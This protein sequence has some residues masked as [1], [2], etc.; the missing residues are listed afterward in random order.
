MN[1]NQIISQ[2]L[3]MLKGVQS[4]P[5]F[6]TG[7]IVQGQILKLYPGRK[8]EI[9]IGLHKLIAQLEASLTLGER[10]NFQVQT[11]KDVIYLKVLG[12][13]LIKQANENGMALLKQLGLKENK[14]HAAFLQSLMAEGIPFDIAQLRQA[15]KLLD[16]KSDKENA[17]SILKQMLATKF[18]LTDSVFQALYSQDRSLFSNEIKALKNL[19]NQSSYPNLLE[20]KVLQKLELLLHRPMSIRDIFLKDAVRE[21]NTNRQ[22]VF[23]LLKLTGYIDYHTDFNKWEKSIKSHM[24]NKNLLSSANDKNNILTA[25]NHQQITEKLEHIKSAQ[26]KIIKQSQLV[27]TLFLNKIEQSILSNQPL[28][29]TFFQQLTSFISEKI[30]PSLPENQQLITGNNLENNPKSLQQLVKALQILQD[31]K[32]YSKI[33]HILMNNQVN[34]EFIS[35][36]LQNQ[37]LIHLKNVLNTISLT[38]ENQL[39]EGENQLQNTLKAMLIQLS[40]QGDELLHQQSTK[41]LHVINGLQLQSVTEVNNFIYAQLQIPGEKLGLQKDIEINFEGGKKSGKIDT[42]FCRIHFYL[43]LANLKQTVIDMNIQKRSITLTI[44]NNS[45]LLK[46]ISVPFQMMLKKGLESLNYQLASVQFKPFKENQSFQQQKKI[47]Q[48]HKYYSGVDYRI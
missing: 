47:Y 2:R 32:M 12:N 45:T 15:L 30:I 46:E 3:S 16:T 48:E 21:L 40:Q 7:Q 9:Q 42:D 43:E 10:Y 36:T 28:H 19:L 1:I 17:G 22:N 35:N 11:T 18:P 8:A 26:M 23:H 44:F 33:N 20:Q 24:N 14:Q 41:L 31:D 6:Q 5:S 27:Q 38:Y 37:F 34:R 4:T 13:K 39:V 25:G 29:S